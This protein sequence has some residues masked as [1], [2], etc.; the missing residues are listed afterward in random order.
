MAPQTE[1]MMLGLGRLYER[2][3][4]IPVVGEPFARAWNRSTARFIFYTP[5][6]GAKRQGSL[7]GVKEYLLKTGEQMGFPFELIPENDTAESFEFYVNYC[8]YGFKHPDQA[9]ACDAAME[10]D[11]VLFKLLGADLIIR[12]SVVEGAPRCRMLMKWRG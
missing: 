5:G 10:M 2:L 3:C 6:S 8:P 12:E 11:R 4:K 7:L 9:K 1:K